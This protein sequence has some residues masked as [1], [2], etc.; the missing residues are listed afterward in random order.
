MNT[1]DDEDAGFDNESS[2]S[3]FECKCRNPAIVLLVAYRILYLIRLRPFVCSC[4]CGDSHSVHSP[5]SYTLSLLA[6]CLISTTTSQPKG[7]T[8]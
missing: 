6:T 3:W 7:M 2:M 8:P 5:D 4:Y 1:V